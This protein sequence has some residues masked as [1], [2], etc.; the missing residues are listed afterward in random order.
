MT[1]IAQFLSFLISSIGFIIPLQSINHALTLISWIVPLVNPHLLIIA[2]QV[3][4]IIGLI[5]I[6]NLYLRLFKFETSWHVFENHVR[7]IHFSHILLTDTVLLIL[8]VGFVQI[9]V[10]IVVAKL[11]RL[12][13]VL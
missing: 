10:H 8:Q 2:E 4:D 5:H 9:V 1:H 12:L 13:G 6:S 3:A 11:Q 7:T